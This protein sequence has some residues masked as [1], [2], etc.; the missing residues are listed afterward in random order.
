[1]PFTIPP[2]HVVGD[3]THTTTHNQMAGVLTT[4]GAFNVLNSAYSG[5]ADP[6]GVSNSSPAIQAALN[7]LPVQGGAVFIP[8]GTY[9]IG[10][11]LTMPANSA[12]I[13][14][15][16]GTAGSGT[17]LKLANA[18]NT[19]MIAAG[20]SCRIQ[21]LELNG[22][23]AN[24][25]TGTGD[26]VDVHSVNS[27][28]FSNLYIHDQF[29]RG[30]DFTSA[31][32]HLVWSCNIK[33]NNGGSG[34]GGGINIDSASSDIH[35]ISSACGSNGVVDGDAIGI[36]TAG[37]VVKIIDTDCFSNT[38][39]GIWCDATGVGTQ[40]IG[41]GIDR[42]NRT[43]IQVSTQNVSI[44]ACTIHS[45]SQA[46]NNFYASI[47]FDNTVNTVAG[48][49]VEGCNFWLDGGITNKV[50]WHIQYV[51]TAT[52]KTHGNGFQASSAGTGNISA[53]SAAKDTNETA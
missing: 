20:T 31:Q 46:S 25:T 8:P 3:L 38:A 13:G 12:L 47:A 35:I 16:S 18:V 24:Q 17:V 53:A 33:N 45:N 10:S 21:D 27:C 50:A 29:R 2:A 26:A 52:A 43:G 51:N 48:C 9:S 7:A 42:N 1:M 34:K 4:L 32:G 41:C 28:I 23:R 44:S 19:S 15:G 49:S 36:Y 39:N 40:I 37:F 22:N 11:L 6:T 5:G 14:A 30:I